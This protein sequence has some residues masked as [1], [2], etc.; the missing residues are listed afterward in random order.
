MR[1]RTSKWQEPVKNVRYRTFFTDIV[2]CT[3]DVARKTYDVEYDIVYYIVR[4]NGKNLYFDVQ[5]RTSNVRYRIRYR[6]R[7]IHEQMLFS[8]HRNTS[9][10]LHALF[11]P[12]L[13]KTALTR[14]V[15]GIRVMKGIML[16][17]SLH[18]IAPWHTIPDHGIT[19]PV[20][21]PLFRTGVSWTKW[22]WTTRCEDC[23]Y[24]E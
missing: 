10:S 22:L 23:Q 16:T 9:L 7:Y 11:H 20:F 6:I 4:Q 21:C 15:H 19:L 5:Y 13:L 24:Q 17:S 1:W 8:S 3:Y 14:I 12:C 2:R 18:H